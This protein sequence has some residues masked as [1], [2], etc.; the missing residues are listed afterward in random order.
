MDDKT[1]DQKD[2]LLNT[3]PGGVAKIALDD[4]LTILY[5]TDTFF[6]LIKNVSEK[7]NTK[8]T[9]ALLRIVYSADIIYV[10]QQLAAQKIRKDNII[11]FNFRTLQSNGSFK[12]VMITGSKT[13]EVHQSGNKSVPVYSC[14]AMDVTEHMLKYK[15][16]EQV[17]NYHRIISELSKELYFEYEIATDTLVFTELFREVFGKDSVI[18]GFRKKLD[19]TKM[20]HPDEVPGVIKVYSSMMSGRKQVRFELRLISKEGAPTWYICYASIIFD[21]NKNPYKVIGKLA[22]INTIKKEAETV[23]QKPQL[24]NLTK[25]CTKDSAESMITE[26]MSKQEPDALSA[27][28]L[29]EIRNYKGVNEILTSVKGENILTTLAGYFKERFRATDIIGRLGL[30]EFIVY[31]KDIRTD[32]YVYEKADQIC[33]EVENRYSYEHTK[34]GLSISIGVAFK[35]EEQMEYSALLANAKTALIMAKKENNNSF[36]VF[37]ET[38]NK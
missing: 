36:E 9:L 8:T 5:A 16:L 21:D 28:L 18:S 24:D 33:K 35:K 2:Q 37:Y 19:K 11:N 7:I 32:R 12:W 4:T 1:T 26:A 15:K 3:V 27:L 6:S 38:T 13:E 22:S 25:V 20:I 14:I 23:T 31:V 30:N 34:N 17:N 10:T 29:I